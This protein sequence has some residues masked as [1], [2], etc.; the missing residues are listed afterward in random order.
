MGQI[1]SDNG[2][3]VDPDG[4]EVLCKLKSPTNE[5]ELQ[6]IIGS[7]NYVRRYI[8]IMTASVVWIL[9]V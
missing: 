6:K 4:M 9:E 5:V 1:F 3:Q 7:F 8:K 2:M